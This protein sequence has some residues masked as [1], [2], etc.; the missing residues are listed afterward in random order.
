VGAVHMPASAS[1]SSAAAMPERDL[2][3]LP[4]TKAQAKWL[5][6]CEVSRP[7]PAAGRETGGGLGLPLVRWSIHSVKRSMLVDS[8]WWLS[9]LCYVKQA[10]TCAARMVEPMRS[11]SANVHI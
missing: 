7:L 6:P 11:P 10:R 1:A 9:G 3:M 4:K 8:D 5:R 2:P